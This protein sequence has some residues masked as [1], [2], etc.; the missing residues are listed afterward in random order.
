MLWASVRL[1]SVMAF[2]FVSH[3]YSRYNPEKS[4]LMDAMDLTDSDIRRRFLS[5]VPVLFAALVVRRARF[6]TGQ[7]RQILPVFTGSG[8]ISPGICGQ[9]PG[10]K[11]NFINVFYNLGNRS[12]SFSTRLIFSVRSVRSLTVFTDFLIFFIRSRSHCQVEVISP[13]LL[14]S[15]SEAEACSQDAGSPAG[16]TSCN[17]LTC[18]C[19]LILMLK[20]QQ[21]RCPTD[22]ITS[23]APLNIDA[24]QQS[25]GQR[26]HHAG[27]DENSNE[28]PGKPNFFFSFVLAFLFSTVR[29]SLY[30]PG[31]IWKFLTV[32]SRKPLTSS[33]SASVLQK[34][35]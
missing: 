13:A 2:C 16:C 6:F 35:I 3:A 4:L 15:F 5:K 25:T 24:K 29:V 21:T 31:R 33:I 28:M 1:A 17:F 20:Q 22:L 12:L 30:P 7:Q 10:L 34:A 11:C 26:Q 19:N 14:I 8:A 32:L 23:R 9:Q 18:R 27:Q